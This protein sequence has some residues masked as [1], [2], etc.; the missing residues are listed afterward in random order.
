MWYVMPYVLAHTTNI[1]P[2]SK[3]ISDPRAKL[4]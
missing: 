3:L 1:S 4:P 2:V